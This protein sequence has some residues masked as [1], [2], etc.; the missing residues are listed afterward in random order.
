MDQD[1]I[2]FGDLHIDAW[3]QEL[4]YCSCKCFSGAFH[5]HFHSQNT[6]SLNTSCIF[7][8]MS[9]FHDSGVNLIGSAAWLKSHQ[10]H[11]DNFT[12]S[13]FSCSDDISFIISTS[14]NSYGCS[15]SAGVFCMAIGYVEGYGMLAFVTWMP[16]HCPRLVV[17]KS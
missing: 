16:W 11:I 17:L 13:L 4:A 6:N 2:F 15:I 5:F 10:H 3:N 9:S 8:C 14:M 1:L 12:R 7:R